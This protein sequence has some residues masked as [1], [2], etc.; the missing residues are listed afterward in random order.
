MVRNYNCGNYIGFAHNSNL[1]MHCY[2]YFKNEFVKLNFKHL[3]EDLFSA[4]FY[5][6]VLRRM[7][8]GAKK[9]KFIRKTVHFELFNTFYFTYII[10]FN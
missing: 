1:E 10:C 3:F 9:N 4:T 8:F 7:S 5:E 6:Q 2:S